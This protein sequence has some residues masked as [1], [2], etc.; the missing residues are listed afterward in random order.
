MWQNRI[1]SCPFPQMTPTLCDIFVRQSLF[2]SIG[3]TRDESVFGEKLPRPCYQRKFQSGNIICFLSLV[4]LKKLRSQN[5]STDWIFL[6]LS[7][8]GGRGG[9]IFPSV[10]LVR[11]LQKDNSKSSFTLNELA[12]F[13]DQ[14]N[15]HSLR[16]LFHNCDILVDKNFHIILYM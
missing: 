14:T 16:S 5:W 4:L 2:N 9:G 15:G 6:T 8:G 10:L 3:S 11:N 13:L 12:N 7:L 1:F